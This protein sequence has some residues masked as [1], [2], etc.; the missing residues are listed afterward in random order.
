[1]ENELYSKFNY[2]M[3]RMVLKYKETE[4]LLKLVNDKVTDN[5]DLFE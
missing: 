3:R 2:E 1:M 5:F 4:K